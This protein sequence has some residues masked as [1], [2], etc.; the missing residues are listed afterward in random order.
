[1]AK[2][3]IFPDANKRTT[4]V[5]SLALLLFADVVLDISDADDPEDNEVYHWI[6]D[7]VTRKR[8]IEQLAQFLRD[9]AIPTNGNSFVRK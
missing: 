1:M 9:C 3:H 2:D 4:V 7:V 5:I 8:S 6:E